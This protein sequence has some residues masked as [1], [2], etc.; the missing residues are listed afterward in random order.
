M[1]TITN[2]Y[3]V[4]KKNGTKFISIELTGSAELIQSQSSSK[5]YATV[6]KCRIPS[7]FDE[8]TAKFM[9]GQKLE[10]EIVRVIV[11]AYEFT[12]KKTGEVITLQHSYAYSPRESA[13]LIGHTRVEELI[14]D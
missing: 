3:V 5:W 11:P 14:S 12:N 4:E 2:F 6:R 10:G 8:N 9:L 13:S 7:T 1:V